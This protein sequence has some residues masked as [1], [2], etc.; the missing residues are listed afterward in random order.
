MRDKESWV[1]RRSRIAAS[2]VAGA[3]LG[4]VLQ[5]PA[6]ASAPSSGDGGPGIIDTVKGWFGSGH[7]TPKPPVGPK[8]AIADRQKLPPGKKAPTAHRVREL[9]AKRTP[10]ARYWKLS[11]GTTQAEV[12]AVP[13]S[14]RSA[15]GW[16]AIDTKVAASDQ[17]GYRY[18]NTTNLARSYF[19][20]RS[21]SL[22]RFEAD[23]RQGRAR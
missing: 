17:A 22:L 5:T 20:S 14:Y 6:F 18:A 10:S 3:L 9:T 1:A 7:S 16:K 11:D 21:G 8:D 23:G 13:L 4:S 2:L 15:R 12:S 19:G